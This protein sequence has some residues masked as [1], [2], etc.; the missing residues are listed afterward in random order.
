MVSLVTVSGHSVTLHHLPFRAPRHHQ[1]RAPV[2]EM[3]ETSRKPSDGMSHPCIPPDHVF[4]NQTRS[5]CYWGNLPHW[6]LLFSPSW[7]HSSCLWT[8]VSPNADAFYPSPSKPLP[9]RLGKGTITLHGHC[10]FPPKQRAVFSRKGI[11]CSHDATSRFHNYKH[12][13]TSR[14]TVCPLLTCSP[15]NP[16]NKPQWLTVNNQFP[17]A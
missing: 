17:F 13:F 8:P 7:S 3:F 11:L 6:L 2:L 12:S 5:C 10:G 4:F 16:Q 14:V 1:R 9:V 15:L